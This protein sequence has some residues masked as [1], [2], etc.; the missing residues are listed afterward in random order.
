MNTATARKSTDE[1][2]YIYPDSSEKQERLLSRLRKEYIE[3]VYLT[4]LFNENTE[5][6]LFVRYDTPYFD[7]DRLG[8]YKTIVLAENA[9][10]ENLDDMLVYQLTRVGWTIRSFGNA[11]HH[12]LIVQ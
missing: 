8:V 3:N 11:E 5:D 4:K 2:V 6:F 9:S 1:F 12:N 7:S 10:R